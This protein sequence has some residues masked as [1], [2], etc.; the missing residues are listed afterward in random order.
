MTPRHALGLS[1]QV[2]DN[3]L[4]DAFGQ[5][6]VSTMYTQLNQYYVVMEVAPQFWQSPD[7]LDLIHLA[8]NVAQPR[9]R[10]FQLVRIK[11]R[12][13][14]PAAVER[15]AAAGDHTFTPTELPGEPDVTRSSTSDS[16]PRSASSTTGMVAEWALQLD[17]VRPIL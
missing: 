7:T 11:Q 12:E 6:E 1:T 8:S 13:H 17:P 5:R 4:Y 2:I 15:R 9:L 16:A 3:T 10:S 14:G